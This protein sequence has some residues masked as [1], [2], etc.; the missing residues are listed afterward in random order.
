M[1]ITDRRRRVYFI[2]LVTVSALIILTVAFN[3]VYSL[4]L[5]PFRQSMTREKPLREDTYILSA[6]E[7][8]RDLKFYYRSV[9]GHHPVF[10]S[11]DDTSTKAFESSYRD[12][13]TKYDS[14]IKDSSTV[15]VGQLKDDILSLSKTLLDD[16][17]DIL[18]I[19]DTAHSSRNQDET[20]SNIYFTLNIEYSLAIL[21]IKDLKLD[22]NYVQTLKTF[23]EHV[24]Y[25]KIRNIAVDLRGCQ[26]DDSLTIEM[27]MSH[28]GGVD[29]YK[30]ISIAT[31]Y[32]PVLKT[33]DTSCH[34]NPLSTE[35]FTGA[36]YVLTDSTTKDAAV[37]F[38]QVIQDNGLG[39]I[40]GYSPKVKPEHYGHPVTF[41]LPHSHIEYTLSISVFHRI[42]QSK[43]DSYLV[44]EYP[45]YSVSAMDTL[46][47]ILK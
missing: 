21:F 5:D 45:C 43:K 35:V 27:F 19:E 1:M 31:R 11:Q 20:V 16:D 9:R 3:F 44:P 30:N 13:L 37:I 18:K 8:E 24:N 46:F 7:A 22:E 14:Y 17:T 38:A 41:Q 2:S 40:I 23:F 12:C 10:L 4:C 39:K 15:T 36:I 6:K 47:S 32:G 28:L 34:S 33:K 26:G 42:D 25:Y 29:S